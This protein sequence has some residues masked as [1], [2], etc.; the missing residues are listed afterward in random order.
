[1]FLLDIVGFVV[2]YITDSTQ[3]S[4]SINPSCVRER[5]NFEGGREDPA[6]SIAS[7]KRLI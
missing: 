1:M 6:R 2:N 5:V 4:K 7:I 3:A